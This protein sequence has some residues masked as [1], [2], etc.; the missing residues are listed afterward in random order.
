MIELEITESHLFQVMG[1]II[2][3]SVGVNIIL[4]LWIIWRE[5]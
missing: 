5:R 4:I 3:M 2:G 1:G